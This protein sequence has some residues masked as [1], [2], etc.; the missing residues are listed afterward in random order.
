M[1]NYKLLLPLLLLLAA[2]SLVAAPL[3][4]STRITRS[5]EYQDRHFRSSA[6]PEGATY[7]VEIM[8]KDSARGVAKTYLLSSGKL[9]SYKAFLNQAP[10]VRHG[11]Y[12]EFH[13]NGKTRLQEVYVLGILQGERRT[14]YPTGELR[15]REQVVP[16]QPTT[17]ECFG[18]DGN[19]VA[20]FP[21]MQMPVYPGEQAGLLQDIGRNTVYPRTALRARAEGVVI[22]GFTVGK[23]GKVQDVAAEEP[24]ADAAAALRWAYTHL[25]EAAVQSVRKLK[26]FV[27]GRREG[28]VVEVRFRV[29]A[30]FRIM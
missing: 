4:D 1:M 13:E 19:P 11:A 17:G 25:Q 22:V 8:L 10:R 3:P 12:L 6:T 28:E 27:P 7:R 9:Y 16:G 29:P 30:T 21:Y 18:P 15:R 24:S 2:G 5:T 23:D 26:P 20:Y 14:Y